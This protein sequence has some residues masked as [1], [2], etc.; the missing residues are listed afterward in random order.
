MECGRWERGVHV[1]GRAETVRRRTSR[2]PF[3]GTVIRVHWLLEHANLLL[4]TDFIFFL[5]LMR[6]IYLEKENKKWE[7][8]KKKNCNRH[9]RGMRTQKKK[10]RNTETHVPKEFGM[11]FPW[12]FVMLFLRKDCR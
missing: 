5:F 7:K 8:G 3:C 2:I 9:S 6:S 10:K 12:W 1:H 11:Y 4:H